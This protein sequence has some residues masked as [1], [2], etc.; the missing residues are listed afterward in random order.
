MKRILLI[1]ALAPL[2][3]QG[4]F[5]DAFTLFKPKVSVKGDYL[6]PS[7]DGFSNT[8]YGGSVGIFAPLKTDIN[9]KMDWK[10]VFK[11]RS[12]ADIKK[13]PSIDAK[14]VFGRMQLGYREV[15][16]ELPF[17]GNHQLGYASFGVTWLR[18]RSDPK[19]KLTVTSLNVSATEDINIKSGLGNILLLHGK[20]R[21]LDLNHF[22]FVGFAAGN[23][24]TLPFITPVIAYSG[25]LTDK[26]QLTVVLPVQA[27]I[28]YKV[29]KGFKQSGIFGIGGYSNG[30]TLVKD[31]MQGEQRFFMSN[32]QLKGG[33]QSSISLGKKGKLYLEGG[34]AFGNMLR[35]R[36]YNDLTYVP[37]AS[38]YV[39]V[40]LHYSFAK[41]MFSSDTF[42][43]D[44]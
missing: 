10:K 21:V 34:Y 30:I 23:I 28:S 43:I 40:A 5:L 16:N 2:F 39:R 33:T 4:Q 35:I 13:I 36:K 17:F 24:N 12:L 7:N 14:Q 41:G 29:A 19:L 9:V 20:M 6:F 18:L 3:V 15:D 11:M 42:E 38:P 22:M 1:L 25:Y 44:F 37:K 8:T 32:F 26:W 31:T 27:K